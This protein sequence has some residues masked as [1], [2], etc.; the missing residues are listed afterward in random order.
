MKILVIPSWYPPN[1]GRFFE[2]LSIALLSQEVS[3][4]VLVN[5]PVSIKKIF[6]FLFF[7]KPKFQKENG[8]NVYRAKILNIPRLTFLNNKRWIKKTYKHYLLYSKQY[9]HPDI[10]QAHSC[11]WAGAVAQK[12]KA[13]FSVPYVISEHRS[14]FIFNSTEAKKLLP[15]KFYPIIKKSLFYANFITVVSDGL[16]PKITDIEPSIKN[17]ITNIPNTVDKK[18]FTLSNAVIEKSSFTWFSLGNLEYV[19]GFDILLNAFSLLLT[20]YKKNVFLIIGGKGS[21]KKNLI[22]LSKKL[23]L[24]KNVSFKGKLSR[25]EVI[26]EMKQADA[27]VLSSRFEAFGV[28]YIEALASG[29]PI[30]GTNAGGQ[31]SIF[32]ESNGILVNSESPKELFLAMKTIQENNSDYNKQKIRQDALIKYEK[33]VVAK[34]YISLFKSILNDK[35]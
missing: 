25:A 17:R 22:A 7:S 2:E 35:N 4:D 23:N 28:V 24:S 13:A 26:N 27:F 6:S 9:G 33:S 30:V 12:I 14:R 20:Q 1:G 31:Q 21:E 15:E 3:V 32:S 29:L 19:K 5:E 10:V 11:I 18:D 8:I 16:I 34:K